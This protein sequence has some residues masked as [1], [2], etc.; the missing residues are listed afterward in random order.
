MTKVISISD[1]AY[2]I[3]RRLKANKSFSEIIIDI[4]KEKGKDNLMKFAGAISNKEGEKIKKEIYE[5]RK[6]PSRRFK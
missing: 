2:E 4:T 3:L 1:E 5:D 6:M